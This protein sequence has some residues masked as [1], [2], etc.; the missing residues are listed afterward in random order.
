MGDT[1]QKDGKGWERMSVITIGEGDVALHLDLGA[2]GGVR[3]ILALG[4]SRRRTQ[5]GNLD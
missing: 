5:F 3:F 1:K 2:D 4:F